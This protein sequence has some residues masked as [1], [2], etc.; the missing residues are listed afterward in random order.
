MD[1]AKDLAEAESNSDLEKDYEL[2]DGNSFFFW[3]ELVR[4]TFFWGNV[5]TIGAERFKCPEVLFQ[6]AFI[7]VEQEGIH[8]LTFDSIMKCDIDIRTDLY[9]NIVMSG[10]TTMFPKIA[11]R[12]QQEMVKQVP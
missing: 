4:F 11:D 9:A 6:P 7:G 12:M 2:P 10:G 3:P 8:K 1:F 5:I